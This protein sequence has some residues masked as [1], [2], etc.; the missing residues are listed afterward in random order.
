M[1]IPVMIL[2]MVLFF[3]L[4][5]GIGFLLNMLLR[6][7]WIMLFMYPIVA[8]LFINTTELGDYITNPADSFANLTE[9]VLSLGMADII[10]LLAGMGGAVVSGIVI[11]M[12]RN[13][14]YQMF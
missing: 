11:R 7:T 12:L 13:R 1:S 3:V 14:G 10:I 4:F 2:S 5:F 8:L 6:G 9:T